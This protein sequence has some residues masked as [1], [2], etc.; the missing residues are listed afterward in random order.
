MTCPLCGRDDVIS[1][2][3]GPGEHEG[4]T[5]WWCQDCV[6]EVEVDEDMD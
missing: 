4:E 3:C 6:C 1:V 2:C 5:V